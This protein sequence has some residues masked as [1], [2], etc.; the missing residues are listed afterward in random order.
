MSA[1]NQSTD[2]EHSSERDL[3]ILAREHDSA[4]IRRLAREQLIANYGYEPADF[5][6]GSS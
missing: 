5:P 2:D 3:E 4:R 6:E 1:T